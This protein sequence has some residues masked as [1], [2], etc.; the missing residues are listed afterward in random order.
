[1]GR[2]R[3]VRPRPTDK[4]DLSSAALA[5]GPSPHNMWVLHDACSCVC[6]CVRGNPNNA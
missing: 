6:V 4:S 2:A 3:S 5:V 1:M